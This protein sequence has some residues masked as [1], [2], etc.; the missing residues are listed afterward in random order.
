MC[1]LYGEEGGEL[2][3]RKWGQDRRDEEKVELNGTDIVKKISNKKAAL[4]FVVMI[5]GATLAACGGGGGT[6]PPVNSPTAMPTSTATTSPG[7]SATATITIVDHESGN[8]ISGVTVALASNVP[9]AT[10]VPQGTTSPNGT[11]TIQANP[12]T[13]LLVAGTTITGQP[14]SDNRPTI[15]DMI[16]LNAGVNTITAPNIGPAP[17]ATPNAIQDSGKFRLTT[18]TS[19]ELACLQLENSTRASHSLAPV[20][21]DEWL[22]EDQRGYWMVATATNS[23]PQYTGV[24]TNYNAGDGNGATCSD[25]ISGG[26]TLGNWFAYPQMVWFD[27][28]SGGANNVATAEGMVDPRATPYPTPSPTNPWP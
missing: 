21:S 18:L 6:T 8:P 11:F 17:G 7:G 28:E 20:T 4:G 23:A 15:H 1:Q 22:T 27:G 24:L 3:N 26:F 10:P 12:G 5:A 19:A 13:Y 2:L 25:M 16:T 9:G 14:G